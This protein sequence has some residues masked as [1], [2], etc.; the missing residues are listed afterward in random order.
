MGSGSAVSAAAA[1]S[2]PLGAARAR[3][4]PLG[5]GRGRSGARA[6]RGHRS[7]P[8]RPR[9]CEQSGAPR[10]PGLGA[11]HGGVS[12][13]RCGLRRTCRDGQRGNRARPSP[14]R[15][16]PAALLRNADTPAARPSPDTRRPS[17]PAPACPPRSRLPTLTDPVECLGDSSDGISVRCRMCRL[18]R[19]R[20]ASL[21]ASR[22]LPY[23]AAHAACI[24]Q[25]SCRP[26]RIWGLVRGR[27]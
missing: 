10:T 12:A 6:R 23:P 25:N 5:R 4:G 15:R 3:S 8:T 22:S 27:S 21:A 19:A 9:R 18:A 16:P 7:P 11:R 17:A 20:A 2:G 13:R 26:A 14:A 1:R 24:I